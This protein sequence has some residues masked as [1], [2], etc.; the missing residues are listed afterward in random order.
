MQFIAFAGISHI[1]SKVIY[2]QDHYHV[3]SFCV[4][5]IVKDYK[6]LLWELVICKEIT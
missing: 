4:P 6:T 1:D 5:G 3:N 2:H